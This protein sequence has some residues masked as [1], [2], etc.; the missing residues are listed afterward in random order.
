VIAAATR[1]AIEEAVDAG[2]L[3]TVALGPMR[4]KGKRDPVPAWVVRYSSA[5][6]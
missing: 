4:L 5:A 2:E 6:T 3:E 1:V